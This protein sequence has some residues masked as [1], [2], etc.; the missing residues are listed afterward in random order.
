[1]N[2]VRVIAT[3]VGYGD[4]KYVCFKE[5]NLVR[6][7]FPSA[8][9][10]VSERDNIGDRFGDSSP[11]IKYMGKSY[12]VGE[13]AVSYD[14]L[15]PTRTPDFNVKYS[16][17]LL[18]AVFRK[19][20]IKPEAISVS[21]SLTEFR[22][23]EQKIM[24]TCSKFFINGELFE[25]EVYVF[26]QGIGIWKRVGSPENV[27]IIDIGQNTVDVLTIDRGKINRQLS[28]GM[29]N[30]GVSRITSRITDFVLDKFSL[31]LPEQEA[32]KVLLEKKIRIYRRETPLDDVIEEFK[33][34]F[35]RKIIDELLQHSG[36][37]KFLSRAERAVLAGGG[38]YF[39]PED[40]R[41]KY[42][43]EVPENPEFAN[44]EGFFQMLTETVEGGQNG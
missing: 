36:L 30:V 18:F 34:E 10:S 27:V 6:G 31:P 40:V 15:I 43:L 37:R 42:G 25:Q 20:N 8:V 39:V 7:K 38:A 32:K 41:K 9:A 21:L 14:T 2:R 3:D 4:T 22:E 26:P 44:V 23:K 5:G 16:P 24:Q 28:F 13:D 11:T 33:E 12:V 35:G 17:L 1:M 19:E 29:D